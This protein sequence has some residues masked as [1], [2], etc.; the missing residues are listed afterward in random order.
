MKGLSLLIAGDDP[1]GGLPIP[2]Q[3]VSVVYPPTFHSPR[4]GIAMVEADVGEALVQPRHRLSRPDAPL[5]EVAE[6]IPTY[7]ESPSRVSKRF[8]PVTQQLISGNEPDT[9]PSAVERWPRS[10]ASRTIAAGPSASAS[11]VGPRLRAWGYQVQ[12]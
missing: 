1:G 12:A 7:P 9:S 5:V 10:R 8:S 3:G 4:H 2:L 6:E 11:G